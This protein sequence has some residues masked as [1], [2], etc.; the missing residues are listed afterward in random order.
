MKIP[1]IPMTRT[2]WT[3]AIVAA[4]VLAVSGVAY[5][6]TSSNLPSTPDAAATT[7]TT[8][9]PTTTT[10][11]TSLP[12]S[13]TTAPA[14]G[15]P[16]DDGSLHQGS[17][18]PAVQ[19][20]QQRLLDLHYDPG[21]ADGK[22]GQATEYAVQAFEKLNGFGPNGRVSSDV[23]AALANPAPVT[24]SAPNGPGNRVEV[25]LAKQVLYVYSGGNLRLISHVST[26]SG[27][28]FCE[29]DG[30]N[31]QAITPLGA[32][33]FSWRSSGWVDAP[34]GKLYNPLYFTS[35][36]VA[37]HGSLSVPT[38]PASHGCVRIPMHIAEYFPSLVS[39]G[40]PIYVTDG[41]PVAATPPPVSSAP[42]PPDTPTTP[43]DDT[44]TTSTTAPPPT[45]TSTTSTTTPS[46]T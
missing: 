13:T 1:N 10:T 40:D 7:S 21:P 26:G 20:L 43:G 31:H 12:A 29:D 5:A 25:D 23:Q 39:R 9:R 3:A 36:G 2:T 35:D 27:A 14:A 32:F 41:R 19:A 46:T 38:Y 6:V 4:C 45:T 18:G 16:T 11:S 34:L 24:S 28:H 33:R 37:I 30:C 8:A 44:P 17:E 15:T 22:F 42:H